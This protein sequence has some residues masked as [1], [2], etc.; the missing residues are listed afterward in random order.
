MRISGT[1]ITLA[2]DVKV[3]KDFRPETTLA[4]TWSKCSDGSWVAADRGS[5]SDTYEA[6][7]N[8]YGHQSDMNNLVDALQQNRVAQSHE[9]TLSWFHDDEHIFGEDVDHSGTISATV[10][11]FGTITQGSW[12]GYGLSMKLRALSPSLV[13]TATLPTLQ[14]MDFGYSADSSVSVNKQ[15]YWAGSYTYADSL[16]D[17]GLFV[18]TFKLASADMRNLRAYLRTVRGASFSV[19][20]IAGVKYPWGPRRGAWPITCRC[21]EWKDSGMWGEHFWIVTLTLTEVRS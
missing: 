19:A 5:T 2:Q 9:L 11:D 6:R 1:G 21:T 14:Y 12:G 10:L 18:G 15:D 8:V 20:A 7:I 3:L 4:L 13:G 17:A 16:A